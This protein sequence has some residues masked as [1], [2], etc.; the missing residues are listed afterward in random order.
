MSG[1]EIAV[2]VA[3]AVATAA[4]A[5]A[6]ANA[7]AQ[8]ERAQAAAAQA[9]ATIASQNATNTMQVANA[10]EDAQR[11][12]NAV[13]AGLLRDSELEAGIGTSG[14]AADVVGQ[15]ASNA[16]LDAL[17]IRYEG[18]LKAANFTNQGLMFNQ[19]AAAHVQSASNAEE[20][21]DIGV[22]SS[23]L[24]GASKFGSGGSGPAGVGQGAPAFEYAAG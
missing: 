16:E 12:A 15:S 3:S 6:Q 8:S 14:S 7:K 11:R 18:Q 9:N 20:A 1:I 10:N 19:Q 22:A 24:G 4:S 17:N 5:A 13:K 23:L 21:G 2:M